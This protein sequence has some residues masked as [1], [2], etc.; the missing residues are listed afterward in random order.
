MD[1]PTC[2]EFNLAGAIQRHV[3]QCNLISEASWKAKEVGRL[4]GTSQVSGTSSRESILL[5]QVPASL[6]L[7]LLL[8]DFASH[9]IA[10]MM[11]QCRT[12]LG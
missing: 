7:Q 11:T 12:W 3:L 4:V 2:G 1:V 5:Y 6:S 10:A 9:K 8:E